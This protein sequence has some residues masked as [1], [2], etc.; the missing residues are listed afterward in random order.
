MPTIL[1]TNITKNYKTSS[2]FSRAFLLAISFLTTLL[3]VPFLLAYL[4]TNLWIKHDTFIELPSYKYRKCLVYART[5]NGLSR[6]YFR[7]VKSTLLDK[8][9]SKDLAL[10]LETSSPGVDD[11]QFRF[12]LSGVADGGAVESL[13]IV[14]EFDLLLQV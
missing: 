9:E 6:N 11:T 5:N 13:R 2:P 12:K 3:L 7:A 1:S 10:A 14:F 4:S 8:Y